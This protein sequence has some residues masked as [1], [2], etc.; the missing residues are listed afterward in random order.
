[1]EVTNRCRFWPAGAIRGRLYSSLDTAKLWLGINHKPAMST[2]EGNRTRSEDFTYAAVFPLATVEIR[3][4]GTPNGRALRA[5]AIK[6]VPPEPPTPMAPASFP[7]EWDFFRRWTR[8]KLKVE[9]AWLRSVPRDEMER[10]C[11][12]GWLAST[13]SLLML[14][15]SVLL[16]VF[17]V[18]ETSTT[19]TST[20][21]YRTPAISRCGLTNLWHSE[22]SDLIVNSATQLQVYIAVDNIVVEV[23]GSLDYYFLSYNECKSL[24]LQI[25][26]QGREWRFIGAPTTHKDQRGTPIRY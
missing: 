2:T 16:G 3:T 20:W 13:S 19:T 5:G 24:I 25:K 23:K 21:K 26:T 4:L 18:V 1:M 14:V 11:A 7:W 12:L 17:C 22:A 8:A 6:A 10:L 15:W 9:M